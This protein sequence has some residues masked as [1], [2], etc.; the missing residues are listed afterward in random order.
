MKISAATTASPNEAILTMLSADIGNTNRLSKCKNKLLDSSAE[1]LGLKGKEMSTTINKIGDKDKTMK[2]KEYN[3]QLTCIDTIKHF[4]VKA[5]SI[6]SISD[7]I[8]AV[9]TNGRSL[10]LGGK[11]LTCCQTT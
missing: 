9:K 4:T 7:K 6:H 1:T 2:T 8:L 5:I 10:T 11:T 3:V